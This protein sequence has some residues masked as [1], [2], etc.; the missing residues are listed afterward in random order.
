MSTDER[1]DKFIK[2]AEAR[3]NN[4]IKQI[5]LIGNLSNRGNYS[6]TEKDVDKIYNA[7]QK[8]LKGMK[9]RFSQSNGGSEFKFKL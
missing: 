8:E 4:A 2:L 5:K 6:F 3:T 7:L 9:E 1:R